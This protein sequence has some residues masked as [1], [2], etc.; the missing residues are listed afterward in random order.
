MASKKSMILGCVILTVAIIV[1]MVALGAR[2]GIEL[3]D[4]GHLTPRLIELRGFRDEV[5]Q[6]YAR[7]VQFGRAPDPVDIRDLIN[8]Q[9][10]S[11]FESGVLGVARDGNHCCAYLIEPPPTPGRLE[12]I[13]ADWRQGGYADIADLRDDGETRIVRALKWCPEPK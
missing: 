6:I 9:Y 2:L 3:L 13:L 10:R 12:V 1:L 11:R 7:R 8:A 5:D 4:E